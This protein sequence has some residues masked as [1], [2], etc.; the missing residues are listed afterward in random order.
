MGMGQFF[1]TEL[2]CV[3]LVGSQTSPLHVFV[4]DEYVD[5]SAVHCRPRKAAEDPS[6]YGRSS[7]TDGFTPHI[8]KESLHSHCLTLLP[9]TGSEEPRDCHPAEKD[10]WGSQQNRA[11]P[12]SETLHW[13]VQPRCVFDPIFVLLK[14]NSIFRWNNR[15]LQSFNLLRPSR[16][17]VW[18][19]CSIL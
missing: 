11:D 1:R 12:V 9:P 13:A 8:T 15:L 5:W 19:P 6:A 14:Y 16:N 4:G 18:H 3:I 7:W 10:W 2:I 17:W